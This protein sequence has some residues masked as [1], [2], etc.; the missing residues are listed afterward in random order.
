[1]ASNQSNQPESQNL[2][3][4]G[5]TLRST[6]KL[7]IEGDS[8]RLRGQ[9]HPQRETR[10]SPVIPSKKSGEKYPQNDESS[11]EW[12]PPP[13]IASKMTQKSQRARRGKSSQRIILPYIQRSDPIQ[14][15]GKSSLWSKRIRKQSRSMSCH[16]TIKL[17]IWSLSSGGKWPR[18]PYNLK[19][20][21]YP[22]R[23]FGQVANI[24]IGPPCLCRG[25]HPPNA[26]PT[27]P[28]RVPRFEA[29]RR[30]RISSQPVKPP[31]LTLKLSSR[32][33]SPPVSRA[34]QDE[35]T[36]K[37]WS[38]SAGMDPQK[39]W[40]LCFLWICIEHSNC[41]TGIQRWSTFV[42]SWRC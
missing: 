20:D 38:R 23:Q 41:S 11:D 32:R 26:S 25:S 24:P 29:S 7:Q 3:T 15:H 18:Y 36:E 42:A 28:P 40:F 34:R 33:I 4:Q 35:Q 1:M 13:Q 6:G 39:H 30:V 16:P 10:H 17:Y 9:H 31:V 14:E 27:I 19:E 2:C 12:T 5:T 22:Q 8:R 37:D 21:T